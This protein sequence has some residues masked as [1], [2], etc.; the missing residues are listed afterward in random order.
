MARAKTLSKA[1][2]SVA[3]EMLSRYI[4]HC[5]APEAGLIA[6][7]EQIGGPLDPRTGRPTALTDSNRE[8]VESLDEAIDLLAKVRGALHYAR[9][10]LR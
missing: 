5:M 3:S 7:A 9:A 2:R 6:L 4:D 1:E 8:V 10:R